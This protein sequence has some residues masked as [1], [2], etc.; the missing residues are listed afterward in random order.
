M[1]NQK[2]KQ[3]YNKQKTN[4]KKKNKYSTTFLQR[5]NIKSNKIE[6]IKP[7]ET[8]VIRSLWFNRV[9]VV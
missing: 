9:V 7:R 4:T 3:T 5:P 1:K 8:L 2:D 6:Y